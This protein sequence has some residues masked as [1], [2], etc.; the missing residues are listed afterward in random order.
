MTEVLDICEEC[1]KEIYVGEPVI[2]KVGEWKKRCLEC[3]Y[4]LK[5][6]GK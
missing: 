3:E 4:K 1:G 2:A 6:E 5:L